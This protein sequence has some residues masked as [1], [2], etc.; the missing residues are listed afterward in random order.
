MS[1][2]N[3]V[4]RVVRLLFKNE[5]HVQCSEYTVISMSLKSRVAS[6]LKRPQPAQRTPEWYKARQTMVT[7]SE[8]S[9]CLYKS[10]K[11]TRAYVDQFNL[12]N[13]FRFKDSEPLNP[14]DTREDY[15]IKKCS[16]FYNEYAYKDTVHTLW[17]KKYEDAASRLYCQLYNTSLLEFGLVPHARLKW[18]AASPDGITPDGVMLEIKC[19]K[20]RKIDPT[21]I[22]LYYWVQVQI[23]LEVCNL[24]QCDFIEC[25]IKELD[26]L[27]EF[28]QSDA[29]H[30][31]VCVQL[32]GSENDPKFVYPPPHIS[33]TDMYLQW[34]LEKL[35]E[36]QDNDTGFQSSK[37]SYYV[38]TK[39]C[40]QHIPRSREWFNNV[41]NEIKSTCELIQKLQANRDDFLKYKESIHELK[42]KVY[43]EKYHATECLIRDTDST[44]VIGANSTTQSHVE[45]NT[46][47]DVSPQQVSQQVCLID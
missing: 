36:L 20:S 35:T 10:E 1:S 6:L 3:L 30:K 27:E 37:V 29:Q 46:D 16:L 38:I 18:L 32:P 4:G 5:L 22:P 24:E 26:S 41:R 40:V 39:N 31:G 14:Y 17:G 42:N 9:S 47:P 28:V 44:F 34:A 13:S 33:T 12:A 7:A 11:H 45:P 21:K 8:A 2:R 23:Q 43:L 15:I 25:E 19:P